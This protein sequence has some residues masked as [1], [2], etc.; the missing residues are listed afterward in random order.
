MRRRRRGVAAAVIA[1]VLVTTALAAAG[2]AP[3]VADSPPQHATDNHLASNANP[4]NNAILDG[5]PHGDDPEPEPEPEPKPEPEPRPVVLAATVE[6]PKPQDLLPCGG[7]ITAAGKGSHPDVILS[8][9]TDAD[10]AVNEQCEPFPYELSNGPN[11]LRFI[12]PG[13]YP[14]A[15]FFLRVEWQSDVADPTAKQTL[16][17]FELVNGG[18]EVTMPWCPAS[19]RDGPYGVVVGLELGDGLTAADLKKAGIT[20]QDGYPRPAV[21]DKNGKVIDPGNPI[22]NNLTQ[23]ACVGDRDVRFVEAGPGGPAH[24]VFNEEIYLLG[25]VK[26]R[27]L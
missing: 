12:K 16:V 9:L 11:V 13:G 14:F 1:G 15:Q 22:D 19:L 2:A 10:K 21:T 17:D 20:D 25:D 18:Y 24:Y 7:V 4:K 23:Y 3:A 6:P 27:T 26:M 5:Q 8:R